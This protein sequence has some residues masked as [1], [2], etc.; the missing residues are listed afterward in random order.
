MIRRKQALKE[1]VK[2]CTFKPQI[3]RCITPR[4]NT[5]T[6]IFKFNEIMRKSHL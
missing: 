6:S 1:E 4:P 2:E 5:R 3:N